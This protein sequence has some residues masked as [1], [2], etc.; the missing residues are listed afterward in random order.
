MSH[1]EEAALRRGED[2][3]SIEVAD[4]SLT[5]RSVTI[6]DLTPTGEQLARAAGFKPPDGAVVLQVLAD[7]ALELIR[8]EE[9]VDL[10]HQDGRFVIVA[11]DRLYLLTI[12]ST[13]FDWPCRIVGGG[14]LRKLG[15]SARKGDLPREGRSPR[16]AD[17][18]PRSRRPRSR[19]DRVLHHPQGVVEA[20]C[21]RRGD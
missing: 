5:Y 6:D 4:E 7:G 15:R 3:Y 2:R 14:Q 12:D 10:R 20:Q 9:V 1:V 8:P 18:R 13:R 11:S 19:R 17:R 16:P 21:P